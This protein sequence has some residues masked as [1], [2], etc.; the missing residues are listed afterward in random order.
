M[1]QGHIEVFAR[2]GN[3]LH[4][5]GWLRAPEERLAAELPRLVIFSGA[6]RWEFP[7][8]R[9][10]PRRD[11]PQEKDWPAGYGFQ[12]LLKAPPSGESS[13]ASLLLGGESVAL[14][15]APLRETR[16]KPRGGMDAPDGRGIRGWVFQ[17]P[18]EVAELGVD[19]HAI[20]LVPDLHRPDL[21][22]DDGSETPHLGFEL[23]LDALLA[24][25]RENAPAL[26]LLDGQ[27]HELV[28]RACGTELARR[29][30]SF[31]PGMLTRSFRRDP[32][33]GGHVEVFAQ[34][35]NRLYVAGWFRA[36]DSMLAEEP[37]RLRIAWGETRREMPMRRLR[38]RRDLPAQDDRPAGRG[39]QV[40]IDAPASAGPATALLLAGEEVVPLT[41]AQL[42]PGPF[43]PRGGMD[44]PDRDGIRGW[45][46]DLSGRQPSIQLEGSH[47]IPL[48]LD[49]HRPD[50]FFDDGTEQPLFGFHLP[51][52]VL[53]AALR[54]ARPDA[55]LFDGRSREL[56]LTA[57]GTELAR[58]S[59]AVRLDMMGMLE[60][61]S[62]GEAVGWLAEPGRPLASQQVDIVLDGTRWAS[63]DASIPRPDLAKHSIALRGG[64]F[65]V[66]LPSLHPGEGGPLPIAAVPRHGTDPI[67]GATVLEDLPP[68][69][70]DRGEVAWRLPVDGDPPMAIVIPIHNA[71]AEL[72]RC[73]ESVLRHTTGTARLILVDDASPDPA[74]GSLLRRWQEIPG[75]EIHRNV[76][77]LG[78]TRSANRGIELAGRDDVVLL[79][80][81]T[82]V[83]PGWLD[84]LRA[85]A[86]SGPRT[87]TATA[88]SNNAGVVS[89]P[90]FNTANAL[91]P[92]LAVEDMA[93]LVRGA[94][95]SLYPAV[96]TGHGFCLYLRRNMLDEVGLLDAEAF[97]RG[98]GEENDLCMRALRAGFE[99]VVDDRSYVWHQ[100]SASFG[101][102]KAALIASA[103]GVLD[104]RYPEY[105]TMIR[106]F[107]GDPAMLAMRWRVRR[108]L[109]RT[110]AAG[111]T[112]R[113]RLLYVISTESG[114]T[115]QTNRDLM[116]A[117]SDRYEPWVLRCDS[118]SITLS[119]HR[120]SGAELVEAHR[121]ERPIEPATHR[122]SEYDRLIAD[123]LLRHGFEL[124]HIRHIA[125]HGLGLTGIC[126]RLNLPVVFS[127]HD[128]YT[129]C[130]VTKLLDAEGR[131]C[132]GP[133]TPGEADCTAELWNAEAMPPLRHRFVHRW[134]E[135]MGGMLEACDA[136]V[137]TS[138]S[139]RTTLLANFPFLAERD[140]R[141]IPHGRSFAR[142]EMLGAEPTL[143]EK[144]RVLVPG[145]VSSSKGGGLVAAMAA[146]DR[147]REVEFHILGA[148][149]ASLARAP[150][151]VLHGRYDRSDFAAHVARI[152]PHLGA[153]LS[154]WPETYCHTLTEC[155]ATG[156][157]VMATALGALAERLAEH[158]GGWLV[159]RWM[160]PEAMLA[161]LHRLRR[162]PGE[163]RARRDAVLDWQA[164]TGRHRDATAMA[165]EYDRLYRQ[166]LARSRAFRTEALAPRV[167]LT[168]G[169]HGGALPTPLAVAT[170]NFVSRPF[171]F[172]AVTPSFPFG[173]PATGTADAV[174]VEPDALPPGDLER[175]RR[176]CAAAGLPVIEAGGGAGGVATGLGLDPAR[177]L[178]EERAAP[179]P[180]AEAD[181]PAR[182]LYLADPDDVL[183]PALRPVFEDLKAL[184]VATL[185]VLGAPASEED[186]YQ[187]LQP[188]GDDAVATLR[189]AAPAHQIGLARPGQ[190]ML[191]LQALGL[192]VLPIPPTLSAEDPGIAGRAQDEL[193]RA[194]AELA[195]DKRRREGM[196]KEATR[197]ARAAILHA[198]P[199][200]DLD[201]ALAERLAE[202]R[203]QPALADA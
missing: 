193:L 88:L 192:P 168:L 57:S 89:V 173:H 90:E 160:E 176:R 158:P 118:R 171:I 76:E 122:S 38:E 69:R 130:P 16:F 51:L 153:I 186:W 80:S 177:W 3:H 103:R 157:P 72:E 94:A 149:D 174:L 42:E 201:A 156:L 4:V 109:D 200:R 10:R 188:A 131:F 100:R 33:F 78:F 150:G 163:L 190:A 7:L 61:S 198:R 99:N 141:V 24:L 162:A 81:D 85:A 82:E 77:N 115:P 117:L 142:M 64:G 68:W 2:H 134:Q 87:G 179:P 116:E 60:R 67:P 30:A 62:D 54:Q 104:E 121:L 44:N 195:A 132:A 34:E 110:R 138:P 83:G 181:A 170:R 182:I 202:A 96:P 59:L 74:V 187:P 196:A 25:L 63:V 1:I 175:M 105:R 39:F 21:P 71:A 144:L 91:P 102:E 135:M 143:D 107:E 41:P 9:L 95:L 119:R 66:A 127:F 98:Y 92:W 5:A 137:T 146:L 20:P 58:R 148:V 199:G 147:G 125:W 106:M 47:P 167:V 27:A 29:S 13:T 18:G 53:A 166:V 159:D 136:F 154:L 126:R 73:V 133:C 108:A 152:R 189:Q 172:R 93:R 6:E 165:V 184:G 97:P 52:E 23:S 40:L 56:I 31:D 26:N 123:L 164:T 124:V 191:A 203:P 48:S 37:A 161:L 15:P 32:R 194:L 120:A 43:Q 70:K 145:N 101:A 79:N 19:G 28:L 169:R 14:T 112:P 183:L 86:H 155:W 50:L 128:F 22:F 46:V 36:P 113:P 35:G 111:S 65:R 151:I 45:V 12:L 180:P 140:F 8:R 17:P 11:L 55:A 75:V 114:G 178:A 139:A 185:H 49:L 197:A 84:G 129:V